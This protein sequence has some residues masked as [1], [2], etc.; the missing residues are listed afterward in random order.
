M[1]TRTL[2]PTV[3][4]LLAGAIGALEGAGLCTA[5]QD[6]E[7]L[8]AD[9]LGLE[10]FR[11]YLDPD[12]EV[13]TKA[14]EA[15]RSQIGRRA[16]GEPLQHVLGYEEFRG[17]P[18]RTTPAALIPRPE[19]ELLVDWALALERA[20]GPW[21]VAVDVGTGT[22]AIAC[23]LAVALPGLR[24]LAVDR[25]LGALALAAVNVRA[26]GLQGQVSLLAGDLLEPLA[27]LVSAVDLVI[28]NPPY[29]P[30]ASLS[31]LP[32]EVREWEPREALDGGADGM[33]VHRRLVARVT[34]VLRPAGWLLMEMGE[35]QAE[36]LRRRME[37]SG[38]ERVEVRRDL[39]GVER[40][41]GGR[42][43]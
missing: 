5:R 12:G 32:V 20:E 11:L 42:R 22:G 16:A 31:S 43:R 37:A 35:G 1:R 15:F 29:I 17:L 3:G 18:L 27:G 13:P 26:L 33:D 36:P 39:R 28:S 34:P 10:R 14:A 7:W 25:S 38:F 40:M 21:R 24:V 9:V 30:T 41:I 19:T 4:S 6:A 8:L 2:A 23:A